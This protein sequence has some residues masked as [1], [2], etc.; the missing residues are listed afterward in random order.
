MRERLPRFRV[1]NQNR[2]DVEVEEDSRDTASTVCDLETHFVILLVALRKVT[3]E[4]GR[5]V[6]V[7]ID[8]PSAE[9]PELSGDDLEEVLE[10]VVVFHGLEKKSGSALDDL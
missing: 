9:S 2:G 4:L 8:D 7:C 1:H 10:H 3:P 6:L 5:A